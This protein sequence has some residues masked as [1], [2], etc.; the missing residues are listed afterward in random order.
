MKNVQIWYEI[1]TLNDTKE[2]SFFHIICYIGKRDPLVILLHIKMSSPIHMNYKHV[3]L[4]GIYSVD[5]N[6]CSKQSSRKKQTQI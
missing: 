5:K 1:L 2:K 6:I 3:E 4:R